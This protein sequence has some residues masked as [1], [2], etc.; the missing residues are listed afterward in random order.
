MLGLNQKRSKTMSRTEYNKEMLIELCDKIKANP[1]WASLDA[2]YITPLLDDF[3]KLFEIVKRFLEK[4]SKKD[5]LRI[6]AKIG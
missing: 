2:S 1:F 3:R 5:W 4:E 6:Y